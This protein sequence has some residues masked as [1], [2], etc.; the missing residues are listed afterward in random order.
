MKRIVKTIA[1]LLL[2]ALLLTGCSYEAVRSI[3][4]ARINDGGELILTYTDGTRD[5]L[6]VVTGQDGTDGKDGKDGTDGTDGTPGE[7]GTV[8]LAGTDSNISLAAAK[9]LCSAVS[10]R[11]QFTATVKNS[12]GD[13]F[14][15]YGGGQGYKQEYSSAGS[16]VLYK[17]DKDAGS[18]FVITNYH[19]VYD[20]SSDAENGI[21][22][23]ITVYLYGSETEAQGIPAVYVGGSLYYDIAVLYIEDNDLIRTSLAAGVTVADSDQVCPGDTAIAVG[24]PEDMGI[25]ASV[26]IVSVDSEY[27]TMTAADERTSVSFR[28]MRIDTAV[29]SGN[30]GGGLFND[31]GELMGIVNAKV[32]DTSVENI[33]YAIPSAVAVSVAEN[34]LDHCFGTETESVRRGILGITVSV[35]DSLAEYEEETGRITIK[36]TVAVYEVDPQGIAYGVLQA[37]DILCTV[38]V[39][40]TLKEIT[41]QHHVI[42]LMLD[43][44]AGDT[45][46]FT[47]LR[48]GEELTVQITV[49]AEDLIS[50]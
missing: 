34:I 3:E 22:R 20:S 44:R 33:G 37:G 30:S 45:V 14:P 17:V 39:G 31:R 10:V 8:S 47:L 32:S 5:N 40:E 15:G 6:G 25:S 29:N 12:W 13:Y 21:S 50:Y 36:E 23:E 48:D 2:G 4:S 9:A 26:G 38:T 19:V 46:T 28:V 7:G 35:S 27:I 16:G 18:A 11:C 42:D 24:N 41:R 49:T 43:V 1:L